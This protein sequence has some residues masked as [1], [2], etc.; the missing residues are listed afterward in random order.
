VK[1][2]IVVSELIREQTSVLRRA[3]AEKTSGRGELQPG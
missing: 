1:K 2:P 3:L